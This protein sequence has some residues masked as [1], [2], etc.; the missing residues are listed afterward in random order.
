VVSTKG[1]ASPTVRCGREARRL[2]VE[3]PIV[4]SIN[5]RP[6]G[7]R[8]FM[9]TLVAII[10]RCGSLPGPE[11][12]RAVWNAGGGRRYSRVP[13]SVDT[14]SA[15]PFWRLPSAGA[16]S[17]A[18][19]SRGLASPAPRMLTPRVA[20]A[21]HWRS[22]N[23]DVPTSD[24]LCHRPGTT[25]WLQATSSLPPRV[26]RRTLDSPAWSGPPRTCPVKSRPPMN[27]D[28]FHRVV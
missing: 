9:T 7:E 24:V 23:Q 10:A 2:R 16:P 22:L 15:L 11:T 18:C 17:G 5:Q 19:T 8:V 1:A 13:A 27:Q 6:C 12:V 28:A 14:I 25:R 26:S 4:L 21:A 20:R 3:I